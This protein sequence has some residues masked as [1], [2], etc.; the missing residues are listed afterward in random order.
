MT[1][2][3]A[4]CPP[5]DESPSLSSPQKVAAGAAAVASAMG[6]ARS[7][8]GLVRGLKILSQVNQQA[9]F[10]CPGCAW[11]DPKGHRSEL[12]EYCENGAKAVAWE[13]TKKRVG[14][15]FFA[16]HSVEALGA[17]SDHWLEK[18]G[19]LT[20][21]MV[22]RPGGSNY[23]TVSW[24]EAFALIGKELQQL[25]KPDDAI[26]YTSGRT[27]NEAAFLYQ[28]FVRSFGTNNLPDCS[29]MC[30]E[31]SGTGLSESI[32]IGKGTVTLEDLER[33]EVIMVMGQNPGTNHPRMLSAL[34]KAKRN[35]TYIIH[36]NP[37]PEAGL[38]SFKNPQEYGGWIGS[39]TSLSDLFVPVRVGGDLALLNGV[40]KALLVLEKAGQS[41][42]DRAFIADKT[43]GFEALA[44][45]L[46][47]MSW[48]GI[49]QQSGIEQQTIEKIA[50]R[51]ARTERLIIT[52]AMGLTQHKHGV[53]NIQAC[54]NLLLMRGAFGKPGAGACPVRG[55]SN[56]QGDRTMGIWEKPKPA[57][58]DSLEQEFGI[59]PPREHGFDTV[60]AIKAMHECPGKVFFAMG[61]NFASATPDT[62]YTAEALRNCSLTVHVSTKLNRSHLI[63]G[64][65]ALILPCL[66]R[67]EVDEQTDGVQF[68]SME[69]SMGMVHSS[70]GKQKPASSELLSEPRIV[71][72]LGEAALGKE[73]S[74]PWTQLAD[75]YDLIRD[76]IEACIPGFDNYNARVREPDGFALP[77]GPRE[78]RFTTPSGRAQFKVHELPEISLPD[79]HYILMT[80]RTHD[81]F[82]TTIYGLD[83]RYRGIHNGRRVLLMNPEDVQAQGFKK[84][85]EVDITSYFKGEER[86]ADKFKI[87]PYPIPR[88][89]L[90]AYFPETNVLVP[91]DSYADRSKTPTSKF[92]EVSLKP[93]ES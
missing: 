56:V 36:V 12:G 77:N 84:L 89:C 50:E 15:D 41:A 43:D 67:T 75:N 82:N 33:A 3:I 10:D 7:E 6:Y 38:I 16:Q 31:S 2:D 69:N 51:L 17:Q 76:K 5:E 44:E 28:L 74:V 45:S 68:V 71:A 8:P 20:H 42:I 35:D 73:H 80:I 85:Q 83:D 49:I 60:E 29:N 59:K 52:W 18:Q 72:C 79:G 25:S 11:P 62:L 55:H 4:L 30:H 24:D 27:S 88:G 39:G 48:T 26:F 1:K 90:G 46:T 58:L 87:V 63:H 9:G 21:P 53:G 91:I 40:M 78:G 22:L 23:Q 19:R 57:F 65:T 92:V 61:G 34:Q 81:Q 64:K 37:L 66:G 47:N 13:S 32:G 14:P 93:S 70:R 54:A 86:Y